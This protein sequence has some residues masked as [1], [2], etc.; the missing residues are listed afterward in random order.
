[1]S[2]GIKAQYHVLADLKRVD[3]KIVRLQNDIEKI[4]IEVQKLQSALDTR[5]LEYEK[6][7]SVFDSAE[8][9]LRQNESDLKERE[10]KLHKAEGKMMEVKTN[11]EYQAALKENDSQKKEQSGLEEQVLGLMNQLDEQKSKVKEAEKEF[12]AYETTVTGEQKHLEGERLK[13]VNLLEE[14]LHA[15]NTMSAQL[16][17]DTRAIY[18]RIVARIKGVPVVFVEN[19]MCLGCHMKMRP[20]LFNEVLGYKAIHRCPSCGKILIIAN[21]EPQTEAEPSSNAS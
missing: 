21:K 20:Q 4:P 10:D 5:R 6:V 9:K 7:K 17:P 13:L 3:E 11:E 15:R 16:A 8:K 12:K 2:E 19:C 1:L 14:Q 18:Q